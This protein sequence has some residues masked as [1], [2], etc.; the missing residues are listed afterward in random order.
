MFVQYLS[1]KQI[2]VIFSNWKKGNLDLTEE[3][4]KYFYNVC[5]ECRHLH[6]QDHPKLADNVDRV[7]RAI[8]CIF[9][10]DLAEAQICL[11]YVGK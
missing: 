10:G 5:A 6:R 11:Q 8:D 4:I 2:G 9:N 7:K 3:Q 1:K